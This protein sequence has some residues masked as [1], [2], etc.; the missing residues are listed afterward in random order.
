MC[1]RLYGML[2]DGQIL[3]YY[4]EYAWYL[5]LLLKPFNLVDCFLVSFVSRFCI[6]G[7][8][9]GNMRTRF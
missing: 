1:S 5:V 9:R 8:T 7:M 2:I 3:I 4:L 6:V